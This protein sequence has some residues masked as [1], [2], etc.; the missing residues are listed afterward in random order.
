[1][2][3]SEAK[4]AAVK[5]AEQLAKQLEDEQ[6]QESQ[7]VS[8]EL[9]AVKQSAANQG[10]WPIP[11]VALDLAEAFKAAGWPVYLVGGWVL[12]QFPYFQVH[13]RVIQQ[14]VPS[15]ISWFTGINPF[16]TKVTVSCS[17]CQS[18]RARSS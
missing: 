16:M 11:A 3:A 7:R 15:H 2:A 18:L 5:R 13:G 8:S 6:K 17:S 4:A 14:G 10:E 12:D 1:M 9:S